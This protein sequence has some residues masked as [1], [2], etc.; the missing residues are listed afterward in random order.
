MLLAYKELI[1]LIDAVVVEG[2]LVENVNGTS[3]DIRLGDSVLIEK[4]PQYI[5]P[6]CGKPG[7]PLHAI[8]LS[9]HESRVV[10]VHCRSCRAGSVAYQWVPPVDPAKKE[11]LAMERVDIGEGYILNPGDVILAGTMETFNLPNNI[12]AEYRLKSSL[13]RVFLEHLHAC[14][15]DPTWQ[16]SVLTLELVNMTKYHPIILH[17][18]MKIGQMC[19]Y[20]HEPVPEDKSYAVRGQYNGDKEA[21]P[22]KGSQ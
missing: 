6:K 9:H 22:S 20:R 4:I 3:I 13:A 12:T 2:A 18:G 10:H 5:C 14:W 16:G 7:G 8:D 21:T 1:A 15:C 17:A 11:A 19:F